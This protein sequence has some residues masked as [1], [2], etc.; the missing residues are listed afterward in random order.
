MTMGGDFMKN[1]RLSDYMIDPENKIA[2]RMIFKDKNVA[3]F[4]L[5][6]AK[7]AT[8]PNHTHFDCAVLI[9]VIRGSANATINGQT[10]SVSAGDLFQAEGQEKVSVENNGSETLSL[11]VTLSPNPPSE[12]YTEDLDI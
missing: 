1:F 12:Q 6:I 8:L 2:K 7:G 11:Y 4:M 9:Q 10:V 3:A 5:N